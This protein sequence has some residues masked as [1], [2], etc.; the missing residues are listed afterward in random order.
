MRFIGKILLIVTVFI[1]VEAYVL[2]LV[3][4]FWGLS[5]TLIMLLMGFIAGIGLMRW[6]GLKT[7]TNWQQGVWENLATPHLFVDQALYLA[8]ALLWIS[9]GLIS[10]LLA[11][12]L[13]IPGIRRILGNYLQ[14]WL[15]KAIT[16]QLLQ[17]NLQV[18]GLGSLA[19]DQPFSAGNRSADHQVIDIDYKD[20]DL[21]GENFR[22]PR[23]APKALKSDFSSDKSKGKFKDKF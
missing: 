2:L 12:L 10:D 20:I 17:G 23:S 22:S 14:Q 11:V 16:N 9:P 3:T 1:L 5:T 19:D 13:L 21:D 15:V 7:V 4:R 8:A 18:F 6:R